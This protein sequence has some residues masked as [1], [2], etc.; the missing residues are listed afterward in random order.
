M[1][2]SSTSSNMGNIIF[3]N[4]NVPLFEGENYDFL[5]VKME[6]L[7]LSLDVLEFVEHEFK[8]PESI[9]G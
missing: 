2:G 9:T 6:T 5:C 7:F 3:S 1:A 4:V 8:V